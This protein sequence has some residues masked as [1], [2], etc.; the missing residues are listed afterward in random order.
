MYL[1]SPKSLP[2]HP[3]PSSSLKALIYVQESKLRGHGNDSDAH[4]TVSK[5]STVGSPGEWILRVDLFPLPP[6]SAAHCLVQPYWI[7][8]QLQRDWSA[9]SFF[10]KRYC[11]CVHPSNISTI[12]QYHDSLSVVF[13]TFHQSHHPGVSLGGSFFSIA[14]S[15]RVG[16]CDLKIEKRAE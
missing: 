7:G 16:L 4:P 10:N 2:L 5:P 13:V 9:C 6:S 14:L 12:G 11:P 8:P 15:R 3:Y 1:S